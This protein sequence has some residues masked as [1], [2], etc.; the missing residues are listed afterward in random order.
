MVRPMLLA[1]EDSETPARATAVVWD[2]AL[3]GVAERRVGPSLASSVKSGE[4]RPSG[5][6][7]TMTRTGW[8]FH[9]L[10]MASWP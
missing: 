6:G 3:R 1:Y 5:Y 10:R 4:E 8:I 9:P 2:G 7:I